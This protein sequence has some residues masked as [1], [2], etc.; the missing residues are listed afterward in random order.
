VN[1]KMVIE[2]R[3]TQPSK[4]IVT[5]VNSIIETIET[6]DPDID[7]SKTAVHFYQSKYRKKTH[8]VCVD[9]QLK[10]RKIKEVQKLEI[11]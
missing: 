6:I 11:N 7:L 10:R 1:Q 5:E 8:Q 3:A 2:N 9:G 4:V